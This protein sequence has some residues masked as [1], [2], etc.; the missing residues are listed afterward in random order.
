MLA[1]RD[2]EHRGVAFIHGGLHTSWCW[3]QVVD[4]VQSPSIA[5]DLPGR[6]HRPG[7]PAA[8]STDDFVAAA[9]ADIDRTGWT[10]VVVVAHSLGGVTALGLCAAMPE[11]ISHVIFIS[12]VTPKPSERPLDE[13][14]AVLRWSAGWSMR[15]QLRR[16]GGAFTLPAV[17]AKRMFCSDLSRSDAAVVLAHCVRETP[18]LALDR[19]PAP[20]IPDQ[21]GRT[22]IRLSKDRA[23]YP[24]WQDKMIA[25]LAPV[26]VRHLASGHDAMISHPEEIADVINNTLR[27]TSCLH[28]PSLAHPA[29]P[30][31][32]PRRV[33]AQRADSTPSSKGTEA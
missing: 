24:R 16:P 17:I 25:N 29:L 20:G 33:G 28:D 27:A 31:E 19:V 10:D 22:Y 11:R 7:E 6:G 15:R 14:P 32:P 3:R 30:A 8:L 4:L 5:I 23:L 21:T 13:L 18:A 9:A 1:A 12:A 26:G 2:E